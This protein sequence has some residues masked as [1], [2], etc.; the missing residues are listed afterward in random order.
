[1]ITPPYNKPLKVFGSDYMGE[2]STVAIAKPYNKKPCQ[3]SK[4]YRWVNEKGE[5]LSDQ[6]VERWERI[7]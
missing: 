6:A 4:P 5:R 1:M 2:W 3:K 7:K